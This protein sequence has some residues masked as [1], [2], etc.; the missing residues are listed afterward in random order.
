MMDDL[1]G[2][3]FELYQTFCEPGDVGF[4]AS[5][6][7]RTYVVGVHTSKTTV[8][9]DPCELQE[10]LS[11]QLRGRVSTKPRDYLVASASEVCLQCQ[12]MCRKR[13]LHYQNGM[14]LRYVLTQRERIALNQYEE[15]FYTR[16]GQSA[17]SQ[18][19]LF[20]YLGDNPS[21]SLT[22]S[23]HG[24]L[25]TFRLTPGLMWHTKHCRWLTAKERLVSLGW[26]VVPTIASAMNVPLV[27]ATDIKRASDLAGNSMHFLN[28][29]VQQLVAL[30][31]FGPEC[32]S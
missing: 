25:P 1:H 30:A 6:R 13:G 19:D 24:Q 23:F 20:V 21:W 22:W 2:P 14:D 29:G 26:P 17:R 12:D 8:L 31:C 28:C 7:K 15:A 4:G 18:D 16:T 5:S 9:K 32:P 3:D 11:G 10:M 27:P